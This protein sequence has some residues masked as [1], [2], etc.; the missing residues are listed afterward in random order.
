MY[1]RK[2]QKVVPQDVGYEKEEMPAGDAN[3]RQ[4]RIE[5]EV[6]RQG[7][8]DNYLIPKFSSIPRGERLRPRRIAKMNFGEGLWPVEKKLLLE[9]LF[10]R[11]AAIAFDSSE[12]GRIHDDIEPPHSI[13]TVP[14]TAWQEPSFRIPAA[15]QEVSIRLI[16]DRLDCGTIERSFGPYRNPWFLVPKK[17]YEKDEEGNQVLDRAGKPIQR[18]RLINCAQKINAVTI[19]DASLPPAADDFSERFAG[20]PLISLLDLFSGYDQCSPARESRDITA[21]HTPLGLMRM[22]TLPQG[23]T[24]AVQAFDRIIR[25]VLHYPLVRGI[26]EPSIDD[27]G[28]RPP[29]RSRYVDAST[30][31]PEPSPIPGVRRYVLESIQATDLV[32]TEIERAGATIS[33]YQSTFAADGLKVVAFV[34]DGEG[35]HPDQEKVRKI[36]EWP[37]CTSITE[38]KAFIGICVYYRICIPRFTHVADPIF[39]TFRKTYT[40]GKRRQEEFIWGEKQQQAM[41]ELKSAL[42]SPPALRPIVYVPEGD[43]GIG[44]IVLGVDASLVGYGAILQQEDERG[45]RHPARYESGLW[46]ETERRY[47]AGKLECRALL[48]SIKKF[49]NYLYGVH[50]LV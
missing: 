6:Y 40:K 4:K 1:K 21:F 27:I 34:C 26:C 11:E 30:G 45:K 7:R 13:P 3:W 18:H 42:I 44:R 36:V 35:R 50:F 5:K 14:H 39:A 19:C 15:L 32:M 37:P 33:G 17:G 16:Q 24:N 23:Y 43:E 28:V 22:T 2:G 49:R 25:K 9:M 31:E 8:Y 10:N 46:T 48:R 47:D 12:K 38:A 20:Y 29:A 41:E